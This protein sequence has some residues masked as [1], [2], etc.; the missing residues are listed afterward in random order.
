MN[1]RLFQIWFAALFISL[2][3]AFGQG[4]EKTRILILTDIENEPDDAESLVRFLLYANMFDVEGIVATTSCWQRDKIADW[5]IHEIVDAY[6]K[7]K[8]NLEKHEKGYPEYEQLKSV[9]K[10]GFPD[11]GMNAVGPG[12]D[13]EGSE[14][15]INTVDKEDDR[16]VWIPVWGGAN[17]LA[18]ALWKVKMTRSPGEV[19][20]FVSRIRVYTISDQDDSGPWMRNTFPGL[21]YICSPGFHE[22]GGNSYFY[23]TW[24]GISGERHYHFP[25]GADTYII[26]NEWVDENIQQNHGPLGAQYPDIA[27]IMEGDT[28]SFLYL[29]Q[30]GLN[31]PEH[32]DYGSWGGRY[33]FYT[34]HY[35]KFFHEPE[36]RPFWTNAD[37]WVEGKDGTIY[38]NEQATIWRWREAFQN[39]FE[40]RMDW[41]VKD[42][43]AA[44][45]PPVPRLDHKNELKVNTGENVSLSAAGST[46]PDKDNLAFNWFHYREPGTFVGNITLNTPEQPEASFTAP[47]VN[48][49][50]TIH[51][52]LEVVDRGKPRLTRYQRVIVT[53]LPEDPLKE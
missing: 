23:A 36:T 40:A 5:R 31:E 20:R 38:I 30:N 52:I 28:P 25:S 48:K 7:V 10:R 33:E 21:F 29:V 39:D 18:Q 22:N 43:K 26:D 53:V 47:E 42:F 13:S 50:E 16:P 17:C 15:I 32:P 6:G 9:I 24:T 14:W 27:Y 11:F 46:D 34:P 3:P 8:D 49:P 45:H 12:K 19:E 44:N 2:Q 35:R 41:T 4:N 37:D 51:I 1:K